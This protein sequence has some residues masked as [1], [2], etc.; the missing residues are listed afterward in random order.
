MIVS[1]NRRIPSTRWVEMA[2]IKALCIC[3]ATGIKPR[4]GYLLYDA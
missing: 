4:E 1:E 2:K 3:I